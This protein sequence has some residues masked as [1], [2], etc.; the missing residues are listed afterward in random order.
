MR[1]EA[2]AVRAVWSREKDPCVFPLGSVGPPS[3]SSHAALTAFFTRTNHYS[4]MHEFRKLATYTLV[5][6]KLDLLTHFSP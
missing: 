2:K 1:L 5:F 6:E 4:F 3:Y